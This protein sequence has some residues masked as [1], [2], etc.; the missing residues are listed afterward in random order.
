MKLA[1]AVNGYL[2]QLER[3]RTLSE[4]SL[5]AYGKDLHALQVF[6]EENRVVDSAEMDTELARSWVWARLRPEWPQRHCGAKS[7][8]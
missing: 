8:L 6:A 2:D 7:R 5:N 3:G 4:N 1:A